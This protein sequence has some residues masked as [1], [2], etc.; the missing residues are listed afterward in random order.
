MSSYEF[1]FSKTT[2]AIVTVA[3]FAIAPS[4]A[5]ASEPPPARDPGFMPAYLKVQMTI[6]FEANL[7][8]AFG[9]RV[10]LTSLRSY[11]EQDGSATNCATG[12][13]GGHRL[14]MAWG[15]GVKAIQATHQ[16]WI[17]TGCTRTGYELLR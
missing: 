10:H 4:I 2:K 9:Q 1:K 13:V 6:E 8:Q 12:T 14:R 3:L 16:Q 17:D 7:S 15:N 11:T 5:I